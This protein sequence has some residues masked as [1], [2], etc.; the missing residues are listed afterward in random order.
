L[1]P[2]REKG[3]FLLR[4]TKRYVTGK[5]RSSLIVNTAQPLCKGRK[6]QRRK[7]SSSGKIVQKWKKKGGF[8][9]VD[10]EVWGERV[11]HGPILTRK[12]EQ[13]LLYKT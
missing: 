6:R 9:Q 3:W 5:L 4:M 8:I 7:K 2:P 11:S 10:Q 1:C 13:D 12:T